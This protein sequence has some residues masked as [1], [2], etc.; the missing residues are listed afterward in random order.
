[1]LFSPIAHEDLGNPDLPDGSEN[2]ARIAIYTA[3]MEEVAR[4]KGVMF[5]NLFEASEELYNQGEL[6]QAADLLQ[7]AYALHP[8]ATRRCD[9]LWPTINQMD[10]AAMIRTIAETAIAHRRN[11]FRSWSNSVRSL[12]TLDSKASGVESS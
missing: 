2:N 12:K 6:Q 10:I 3:A 1:M 7:R 5:V 8:N 11:C 4:D 9:L